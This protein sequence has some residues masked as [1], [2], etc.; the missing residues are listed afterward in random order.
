MNQGAGGFVSFK[1]HRESPGEELG[2]PKISVDGT[3]YLD[4]SE[5]PPRF[6]NLVRE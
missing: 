3:A 4:T 2:E 5:T 1:K 6:G